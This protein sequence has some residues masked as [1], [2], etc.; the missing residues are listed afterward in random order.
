M[1][2]VIINITLP[3]I[4]LN[5]FFQLAS[6]P[7]LI[8]QMIII[9]F[10][11]VIFGLVG[12]VVAY[13]LSRGLKVSDRKAREISLLSA[14]GNTALVGIP[15]CAALYGARGAVF[16]A[17]F[18]AGM[19]V[20]LWTVGIMFLQ[21]HNKI[22][23]ANIRKALSTP[24]IAVII[25]FTM[26]LADIQP[27]FMIQDIVGTVSG[28]AIP[29]AMFYIGMLM[30]TM[31][32]ERVVIDYK[33]TAMPIFFKLLLFPLLGI[34]FL[35]IF[36]MHEYVTQIVL[37]QMAVPAIITAPIIMA[38]YKR[39]ENLA[40]L[41]TVGSTLLALVSISIIIYIGSVLL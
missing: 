1:I 14:F 2:F 5:G 39:D 24:V 29:L 16:A 27:H 23:L 36:P 32:K 22:S 25:G 12:M 10:F 11:S 35:M 40:V 15:L 30:T 8:N 4:I 3:A 9:F 38:L 20:V 6:D 28:A 31:I 17:V 7:Q 33:L 21:G 13:G 41:A 26:T 34:I 18:D 19:C 37:I